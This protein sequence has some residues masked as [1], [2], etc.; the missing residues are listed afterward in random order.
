MEN[1]E[2]LIQ[3][4]YRNFVLLNL[5]DLSLTPRFRKKSTKEQE[6]AAKC[7]KYFNKQ[8]TAKV[9]QVI[10]KYNYSNTP[11]HLSVFNV[12]T[13]FEKIYT[14]C[15]EYGFDKIKLASPFIESEEFKQSQKNLMHQKEHISPADGYMFW[16]DIHPTMDTHTWLAVQFKE[17]YNA[18]FQFIPP[19]PVKNV[20]KMQKMPHIH[21]HL[22][23][24]P[25]CLRR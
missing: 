2:N 8:L 14:H 25:I 5:P 17:A 15:E 10:E 7:S 23:L 1:F 9:Q 6:N 13:Q 3:Q 24:M 21:F 22:H 12:S 19:E 18:I 4:G 16:D 20:V 11:L